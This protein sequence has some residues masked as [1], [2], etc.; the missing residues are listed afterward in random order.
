MKKLCALLLALALAALT[1]CGAGGLYGRAD[2]VDDENGVLTG[3][4]LT[5]ELGN[6]HGVIV[7][8][9]TEFHAD[10][11]TLMTRDGFMSGDFEA[12][13]VSVERA[14]WPQRLELPQGG[15]IAARRARSVSVSAYLLP[16]RYTLADGTELEVWQMRRPTW[17][18]YRLPDGTVLLDDLGVTLSGLEREDIPP[19]AAERIEGY[20]AG[21]GALYDLDAELER[22][23]ADYAGGEEGFTAYTA[24]QETRVTAVSGNYVNLTTKLTLSVRGSLVDV[25]ST[26][27]SFDLATGEPR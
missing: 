5:D 10:A 22:A 24:G 4:V 23:Y 11:E 21:R 19:Q 9:E 17:K 15:S 27:E 16:E 13:M 3:L 26:G 1:G 8:G 2:A 25:T 18:E 7:D 14:P 20:Y 12:A 6:R